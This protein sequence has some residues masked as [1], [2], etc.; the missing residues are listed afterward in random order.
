MKITTQALLALACTATL[1]A[2]YPFMAE[3]GAADHY[4]RQA[5]SLQ[6]SGASDVEIKRALGFDAGLQRVDVSGQHAFV[7]PGP[8]DKRGPCPGLNALANH[9]YLPHNGMSVS[10]FSSL[11]C[12]G[13]MTTIHQYYPRSSGRS[14]QHC[15]RYGRRSGNFPI[16][17]VSGG[18]AVIKGVD[19]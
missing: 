15:L 6:S 1:S 9:G 17:I 14:D 19:S 10:V 5:R 8:G 13:L 3:P 11:D 16:S 12:A 2:A 4:L 7:A 18:E